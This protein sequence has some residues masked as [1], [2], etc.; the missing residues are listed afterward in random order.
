MET[1]IIDYLLNHK[2]GIKET[3]RAHRIAYAPALKEHYIQAATNE[4]LHMVM[5][6]LNA[7]YEE[8]GCVINS[9]FLV[10]LLGEEFYE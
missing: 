6:G 3:L 8:V 4:V 2:E 7:N 5:E 9:R 1:E 10:R